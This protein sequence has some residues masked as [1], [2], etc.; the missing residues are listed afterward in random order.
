MSL[1]LKTILK[2]R[3][4]APRWQVAEDASTNALREALRTYPPMEGGAARTIVVT[5][6]PGV[7]KTTVAEELAARLSAKL[8]NVSELVKSENLVAEKD[9]GRG[10]VVADLRKLRSRVKKIL[11]EVKDDIVVEGHYAY[12]VI[13][14]GSAPYVFIL[15]RD[16]D[17]L[18]AFLKGRG[19]DERKVSENV[20]A[21]VLDVCL[22]S[23]MNRFGRSRLH[24]IDVT[25]M[26]AGMVVKE[27]LAVL[28][29]E[30]AMGLGK[31]DWLGKLEQDGRLER[32]LSEMIRVEGVEYGRSTD[33][34]ET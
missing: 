34:S 4:R 27:I 24:E 6:T 15:R 7:G 21:E 13:P 9:E 16:P 28:K 20:A 14:K 30:K 18:E 3:L 22:I 26:D 32:F 31:V 19:Y 11:S 2:R 8:L 10:T 17:D 25:H 23:A 33:D 29:G 1:D 12:D 5:G